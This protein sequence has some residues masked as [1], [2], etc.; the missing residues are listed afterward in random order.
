MTIKHLVIS[1][2]GPNIFQIYGAYRYLSSKNIWSLKNIQSIHATSAGAI[3]AI[4]LLLDISF[5]DI[6]NYLINRPYEHLFY[7]SPQHILKLFSTT[8]IFDISVMSEFL[9]PLFKCKKYDMNMTLGMLFDK[10]HIDLNMYT[11][12]L[13]S[14]SG[15]NI[16]HKTHPNMKLIDA[17]YSSISIPC[18]FEPLIYENNYYLDGGIFSNYPLKNCIECLTDLNNGVVD[19]NEIL[20][21]CSDEDME[22]VENDKIVEMNN[23]FDYLL[24]I[25][26]KMI[27]HCDTKT[28]NIVIKHE[29]KLRFL[30]FTITNWNSLINSKEMREKHIHMPIELID[31]MIADYK[32]DVESV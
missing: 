18:V 10:T 17:I 6:D 9:E 21:V 20:G 7:I 26:T 4:I 15:A 29:L 22:N 19:T 30:P 8:G 13:K 16:S 25:V 3:I 31:K 23:I 2:G 28:E 5:D 24:E 14:F 27:K 1:G 12:E 11:T 32:W